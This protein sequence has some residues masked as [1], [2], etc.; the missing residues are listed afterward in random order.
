MR[1]LRQL[2]GRWT[3]LGPIAIATLYLSSCA[4]TPGTSSN[5]SHPPPPPSPTVTISLSTQPPAS[6]AA[7]ATATIAATV[8][9]D[10]S[11]G[12][13]D[14]TCSSSPCGSFNP[15]HTASG[16]TTTYTAP[17]AAGSVMITA[18][19]TDAH[20]AMASAMVTISASTTPSISLT[21]APPATL[22]AGATATI[23]ATVTNDSSNAGVD[24]TCSASPCG[25]FNPAH[26]ASGA[27]TTYT[28]PGSATTV[29][30]TAASTAS[31]SVTVAATVT[32]SANVSMAN[33]AAG[34]YTFS[35]GGEDSQSRP[36]GVVGS[37]VLDGSG[38]VT[39]GEQDYN[40]SG[41]AVS[42]E[43]TPDKITGGA[44]TGSTNNQGTLTLITNNSSVGVGGTETFAVSITNTKHALIAEFDSGATS[45]GAIDL[46]TISPGGLAQLNGPTA[47]VLSGKT[48]NH[49]E[50]YGGIVTGHGDGTLRVQIDSNENGTVDLNGTNNGT[51]TAPDAAGR[52]IMTIGSS[53][54]IVYYVVTPKVNRIL[55]IDAAE[56][57]LGSQFAGVSSA[58]I[59]T[60]AGQK[61]AFMNSS[62]AAASTQYSAAGFMTMDAQGN[63][64]GFADV[65][66]NGK[67]TSAPFQG[68]FTMSSDGY[69][70][71]TITPGN[72][73][74]MSVFGLYLAD[75]T[76]DLEDP[77]NTAVPTGGLLIDLD[78]KL[79]GNGLLIMPPAAA[80]TL[81]GNFAWGTQTFASGQESDA[82][83]SV[84]ISGTTLTGT[85]SLNDLSAANLG[86]AISL[87]G[88]ITA[89]TTN[90]GR[91]TLPL[92]IG[93]NGTAVN[94]VL[95][96]LSS[97]EVI[98]LDAGSTQ[99]GV[100]IM[101]LQ[102]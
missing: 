27:T 53:T 54:T 63:V 24:W 31:P 36:Y 61:F 19:A 91:F 41:G 38:N 12:G 29:T 51:Y 77:N 82:V 10:S 80:A 55:D 14:W 16:A 67:V 17:G 95:Y 101:L 90:S 81:T 28:A 100:G 97:N 89:D 15:A 87:S 88:A 69:G 44:F 3:I 33:L 73:Q 35:A 9:N 74:D 30:I 59:A 20:T 18:M 102:Q 34:S 32:V 37:F 7:N 96:Q 5:N 43:P 11:N 83:G 79:T 48:S 60:L 57:D 92:T 52:G 86:Q 84:A 62:N 99:F 71:V 42:P 46:Q 21:Q 40:S 93:G 8:S 1:N 4:S 26:T 39:S 47:L 98:V 56:P 94:F 64:T 23:S 70:S 72:T 49:T 2:C 6:L 78:T 75:P 58:S 68:T 45:S 66:E 76:V 22:A 13:V 25:S 65:D 85:E 50:V